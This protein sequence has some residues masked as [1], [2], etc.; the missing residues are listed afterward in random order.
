MATTNVGFITKKNATLTGSTVGAAGDVAPM[1]GVCAT[2][3]G[4]EGYGTRLDKQS[5]DLATAGYAKNAGVLLT[6]TGT[7]AITINAAALA[8]A[9]GVQIAGDTAFATVNQ[10]I[11]YNTG[12]V[13]L[14]VAPAG[15]NPF[16]FPLNGT[17][18]TYT[19]P[20]G[21]RLVIESVAGLTVDG[22]HKSITVTP[23][24]GGTLGIC[25]GGA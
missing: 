22:T 9:T 7:T 15:S 8:A 20:A 19:V 18:P 11:L 5:F 12:A 10:I 14:I 21:S 2:Q 17:T 3:I 23:T 25:L 13:D 16:P 1:D 4:T 6:L 24:A